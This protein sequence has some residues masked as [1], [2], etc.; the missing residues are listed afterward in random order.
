MSDATVEEIVAKAQSKSTFKFMDILRNGVTATD[1]VDVYIESG[2]TYPAM[3]I[4]SQIT[5]IDTKIEASLD[6]SNAKTAL[7][8][9]RN[10]L[11]DALKEFLASVEDKKCTFTIKGVSSGFREDMM[12]RAIEAHPYE[13]E[14]VSSEF[15]GENTKVQKENREANKLFTNLLW[16]GHLVKVETTM[17]EQIGFSLEEVAEMRREL[18]E[19][20][21]TAIMATMSK[22]DI[23]VDWFKISADEGFLAKR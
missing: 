19:A 18:P 6:K 17:S 8:K 10:A 15:T 7:I 5:A 4:V 3:E 14:E 2:V 20:A 23:A 13:Y 12:A 22:V 11:T 21:L 16:Q 9:E 1:T